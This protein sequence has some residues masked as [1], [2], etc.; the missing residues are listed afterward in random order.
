[1]HK[2]N[3]KALRLSQFECNHDLVEDVW[4]KFEL[5][6][7]N[8]YVCTVYIT[9]KS[10]N[11]QLLNAFIE[12]AM[13][14]LS[15]INPND[16]V[17]I[18]GDFNTPE[19]GWH[20]NFRGTIQPSD[21]CGEKALAITNLISFGNLLQHNIIANNSNKI[22]DLI[23]CTD[24]LTDVSIRESR[25][26]L[27]P[28][29]SYHP[30]LEIEILVKIRVLRDKIKKKFNFRKARYDLINRAIENTDWL[31]IKNLPL[32]LAIK[33]FYGVIT[34][35]IADHTPFL[36]PKAQFPFWFSSELRR[37]L[38]NK[39]RARNRYKKSKSDSDYACYS[40]LRAQCKILLKVDNKK[41]I[42]QLQINIHSNI[43]LFF[44]YTKSQKQTNTYPTEFEFNGVQ[45]SEN[46]QICELFR[47][48]FQSTFTEPPY[49]HSARY[50]APNIPNERPNINCLPFSENEIVHMLKSLDINK[51]GGPD[52]IPNIFLKSTAAY[53]AKPLK[54]IFNKSLISGVFPNEFK[55]AN[56][57]P[58]FKKGEKQQISNYRPISMLNTISLVFEKLVAKRIS[59]RI[60]T[61][62][63]PNQHG[64][65]K[66]RSTNSNLCE[67]THHISLA[68]DEG[69]ELHAIYTD[70]SKAFDSVNHRILL[71][72]LA[73]VGIRGYLWNWFASYLEKRPNRVTFNGSTSQFFY[74]TSGVPQGSVLGPLLFNIFVND[75]SEGLKCHHLM[76]ADDMKLFVKAKD[77]NDF[78]R[79]Q[80]DLNFMENWCQMNQLTLNTD[81]CHHIQFT[82]RLSPLQAVYHINNTALTKVSQMNDLGVVYDSKLRFDGH[83]T[84]ITNKA[85]KMLGFILRFSKDFRNVDCIKMLYNTLVRPHLEYCTTAWSPFYI[86]SMHKIERIQRS[87]TKQTVF[88]VYRHY[89]SYENRLDL[90]SLTPLEKRR[91]YFDMC[92][93]NKTITENTPPHIR[94]VNFRG[95]P[96]PNRN[97]RTFHPIASRTDYGQKRNPIIRSQHIFNRLFINILDVTE[98]NTA[99][100]KRELKNLL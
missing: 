76:Y 29:D 63:T 64:F 31:S 89:H 61:I 2:S 44:A 65:R 81:K 71:A 93:L 14:N 48:F 38:K 39:D 75:L 13:D 59:D 49:P 37:T 83:I 6:D 99:K 77:K 51:N 73:N 30:P 58:I 32:D 17:I 7:G 60:D 12:K 91:T 62:L 80:N 92:F 85:F 4:A 90:L 55:M 69:S 66:N 45:T 42:D 15:N 22:L 70:F 24:N 20:K 88:R 11:L 46:G 52:A 5:P 50:E 78:V 47:T 67:F 34:S 54:I 43:K 53:I 16:R 36:R 74:P 41:Y 28:V 26:P 19:L 95:T 86:G 96:Y 18:M 40:L 27:T 23:L 25:N 72:K 79:L 10:N 35:A 8:L 94:F 82:N 33:K 57:T 56:V 97:L 21:F 98:R 100:F 3:M 1:M 87:F 84:N 68:L 9:S